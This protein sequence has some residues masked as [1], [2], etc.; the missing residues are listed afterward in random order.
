MAFSRRNRFAGRGQRV[1]TDQFG[2]LEPNR[3]SQHGEMICD[4]VVGFLQLMTSITKRICRGQ[5]GSHG[6]R[7]PRQCPTYAVVQDPTLIQISSKKLM[8]EGN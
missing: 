4:A 8:E 1:L 6:F 2:A 5:F 7:S 3:P